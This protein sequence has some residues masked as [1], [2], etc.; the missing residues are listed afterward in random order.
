MNY[1]WVLFQISNKTGNVIAVQC[2]TWIWNKQKLT[3]R[4]IRTNVGDLLFEV[5]LLL[6]FQIF[7][8]RVNIDVEFDMPE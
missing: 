8:A 7:L 2:S 6:Q 3:P 5:K 4:N 1:I